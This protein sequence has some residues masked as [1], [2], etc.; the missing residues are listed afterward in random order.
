[1]LCYLIFS[2]PSSLSSS[3]RK[4]TLPLWYAQQIRQTPFTS[5]VEGVQLIL[6]RPSPSLACSSSTSH[7]LRTICHHCLVQ[8]R[9]FQ[10]L[11]T[12]HYL[13]VY[14]TPLC[15]YGRHTL[16]PVFTRPKKSEEDF[17]FMDE[18][19]KIV[20]SVCSAA[21]HYR[22]QAVTCT[23]LFYACQPQ[24]HQRQHTSNSTQRTLTFDMETRKQT[25]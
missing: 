10:V 17:S 15:F 13:K 24:P 1:M 7:W 11:F 21:G 12:P 18:D 8:K 25:L 3:H 9:A 19:E 4:C 6:L 5:V 20:P 14:F 16:I 23:V 2:L 22:G